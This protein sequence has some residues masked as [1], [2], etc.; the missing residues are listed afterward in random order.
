MQ[1]LTHKQNVG[2]SKNKAIIST[3]I[4]TGKERRF[5]SMK[6]ASIELGISSDKI[7]KICRNKYKSTNSKKDKKKNIDLDTWIRFQ[8]FYFNIE[9]AKSIS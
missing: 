1:I 5:I 3:C 2:K 7:S 4:E 8:Y 6:K 9:T